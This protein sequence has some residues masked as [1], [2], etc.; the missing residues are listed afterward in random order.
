MGV[1]F[2]F[3]SK[4]RAPPG[5]RI[6][7]VCHMFYP[8]LTDELR[9][10]FAQ[11]PGRVDVV[12]STD[13]EAKRDAISRVKGGTLKHDDCHSAN[14]NYSASRRERRGRRRWSIV[15]DGFDADAGWGNRATNE[16]SRPQDFG[17]WSHPPT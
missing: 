4:A 9:E 15:A 16:S 2:G 7:A 17:F 6:A 8:E 10:A 13:T 12:L 14:R 1:P 5:L 3:V 11:I